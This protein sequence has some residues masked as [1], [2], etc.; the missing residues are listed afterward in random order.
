MSNV[1]VMKVKHNANVNRLRDALLAQ[2]SEQLEVHMQVIGAGAL[3]QAIKAVVKAHAVAQEQG[4]TVSM[5]MPAFVTLDI[6]GEEK[7]GLRIT[8]RR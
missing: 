3:N 7:T 2:L 8:V 4:Y 1:V 5:E 6:D